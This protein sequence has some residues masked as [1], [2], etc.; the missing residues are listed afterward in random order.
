MIFVAHGLEDRAGAREVVLLRADHEQALAALGMSRGAPDR[1]I[2]ETNAPPGENCAEGAARDRIDRTHVDHQHSR[3]AG[4]GEPTRA[5][6]H[7]RDV[8]RVRQHGD[9][10]IG[11]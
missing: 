5:A 10:D 2:D 9:D 4:L 7:T 3:S 1:G 6:D 8:G 11:G